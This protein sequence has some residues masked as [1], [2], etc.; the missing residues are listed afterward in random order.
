MNKPTL[1]FIVIAFAAGYSLHYWLD[2]HADSSVTPQ[3]TAAGQNESV[4]PVLP[5][6]RP[7]QILETVL[8]NTSPLWAAVDFRRLRAQEE[9]VSSL[10]QL[11]SVSKIIQDFSA[12][13]P[14]GVTDTLHYLYQ[15]ADTL[16]IFLLP[17]EQK[18]PKKPVCRCHST[19]AVFRF[20]KRSSAF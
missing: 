4:K 19:T 13:I 9:D 18:I 12:A 6:D 7:V 1:I 10:F 8:P 16:E 5:T 2:S 14:N 11:A 3:E 15:H 20:S 17:P